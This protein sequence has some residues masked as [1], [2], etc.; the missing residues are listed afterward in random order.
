M[1]Y[2]IQNGT[3]E[4][5]VSDE[6]AQLVSLQKAGHE[7]LWEGDPQY[8]REHA[9]VLF[10]FVG[11]LFREQYKV[12]GKPY[13]MQ[14]HG[15]AKRSTFQLLDQSESRITL[16][17]SDSA[18]TRKVFPF[19]FD[20]QVTY[21]LFDNRLQ[22]SFQVGNPGSEV[23]YFG[24]GGH[25]GFKVPLEEGSSFEDWYLEFSEV[26]R[27]DQVIMNDDVLVTGERRPYPLE[28]GRRLRLHH[29][30]FDHDAVVLT[31]VPDTVTLKSDHS[32]RSVSVVFPKMPYVGFWHAVKKD[33]PYVAIEPWVTLPAREGVVEEFAART[34]LI[35][36]NP[37]E[38]YE[39]TWGIV[40]Q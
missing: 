25:P 28:D 1:N 9:P 8:W 29:D 35:R 23:M 16:G 31:N 12:H 3:L 14:I 6:G 4:A 10:P 13:S 36:L 21:S 2:M 5:V 24:L 30:L 34:D 15:F 20:F 32:D 37:E 17:L 33:A 39:N 22:I 18:E 40:L 7:Y 19:A 27:P 26:C 38:S 11:R